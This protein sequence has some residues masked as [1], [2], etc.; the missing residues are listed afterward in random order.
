V[1]IKEHGRPWMNVRSLDECGKVMDE[2]GG[3]R[4]S[5]IVMWNMMECGS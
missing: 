5:Y 1:V 2:C 3:D 4:M